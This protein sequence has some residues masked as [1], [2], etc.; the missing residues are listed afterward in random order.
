MT[1]GVFAGFGACV[2]IKPGTLGWVLDCSIILSV[3]RSVILI[4]SRHRY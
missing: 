1:V 4:V 3:A 2:V